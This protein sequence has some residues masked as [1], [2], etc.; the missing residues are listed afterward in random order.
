MSIKIKT[1]N[2][3]TEEKDNCRKFQKG[4]YKIGDI[5]VIN[6]GDCYQIEG[7][8]YREE[9]GKIV[10]DYFKKEYVL[11]NENLI[12][13]VVG[14][15]E[16]EEFIFGFFTRK[17]MSQLIHIY[18]KDLKRWFTFDEN[19]FKNVKSYK[20]C[21]YDGHFYHIS[22]LTASQFKEKAIISRE[23]KALFP[24]NCDRNL[25]NYVN[26]YN[27][28]QIEENLQLKFAEKI[29]EDLSFGFEFETSNGKIPDYKLLNLGVI[30]LRDGSINGLEYATIPLTGMKG[31]TSL[32]EITESL[33]KF[34]TFDESCSLHLHIGNIPRTK[35]F[36]L[37]FFL[38][39]LRFQDELYKEH[40]I[41][42]KY[43]FGIKRK[44]YS[45]PYNIYEFISMI[46]KQIASENIDKNFGVL[47]DYLTDYQ[48]RFLDIKN[49]EKVVSHPRDRENTHKWNIE[50]R[51]HF[52][53]FIPI[54][55]GNKQTI[56]FRIHQPTFNFDKI[57]EFLLSNAVYI[58]FVKT[59]TDRILNNTSF[60]N[61][62]KLENI[63]YDHLCNNEVNSNII[64]IIIRNRRIRI[65]EIYMR[66]RDNIVI[67]EKDFSISPFIY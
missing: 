4:W 27:N 45:S 10:Y 36:I 64:D 32:Y 13:G 59:N 3:N 60:L 29:I 6:S 15:D 48:E 17:P 12:E 16:N 58:N 57:L 7:I 23:Y 2:G 43:N 8:Y 47:Y 33:K 56:E 25:K 39:I 52:I 44:N 5:K 67:K 50:K 54:I 62:F 21:I 55:F 30:P 11:K 1:I 49:L 24:Y 61:N 34:T 19:I 22:K 41:Y 9:T 31:L 38:F 40:P 66:T 65:D 51:Y 63:I 46:D 53:N 26:Y 28:L 20:L 35:E 37:A 42:K 14:F 18:G